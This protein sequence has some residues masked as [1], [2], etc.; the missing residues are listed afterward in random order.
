MALAN[1]KSQWLLS[2]GTGTNGFPSPLPWGPTWAGIHTSSGIHKDRHIRSPPVAE[3]GTLGL[4]TSGT[5][6][7]GRRL[8]DRFLMGQGQ[9]FFLLF[10]AKSIEPF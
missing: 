2:V 3:G 6:G 8:G 5:K 1:I 7:A 9:N 4:A 10:V